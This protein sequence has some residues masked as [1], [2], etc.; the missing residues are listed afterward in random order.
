MNI[1]TIPKKLAQKRD[2]KVIPRREYE[3]FLSWKKAVRVRLDE[4]WFWAPEWQKKEAEA[5]EAIHKGKVV[6]PFSSHQKL[7]AALKRKRKS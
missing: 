5:D 4:Q 7:I 1:I 3:E 6:G 2:F